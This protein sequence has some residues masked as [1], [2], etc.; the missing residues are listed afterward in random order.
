MPR[1]QP[2]PSAKTN[3]LSEFP[4]G[5]GQ[6]ETDIGEEPDT[7]DSDSNN[8]N[9]YHLILFQEG[10]DPSDSISRGLLRSIQR[11]LDEVITSARDETAIDFGLS[12]QEEMLMRR[13]SC[14]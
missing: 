10:S 1:K 8:L 3:K 12:H 4:H 6:G 2:N 13:T 14:S 5:S 11:Q 7:T 9:Y